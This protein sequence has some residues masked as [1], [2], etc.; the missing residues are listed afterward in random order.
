MASLMCCNVQTKRE[1]RWTNLASVPHINATR[2]GFLL[3]SPEK[4]SHAKTINEDNEQQQRLSHLK[5]FCQRRQKNHNNK[6][7][8]FGDSFIYNDKKKFV[9][10][11]IPK[12]A[13]TTWKKVVLYTLGI[14]DT[15]PVNTSLNTLYSYRMPYMKDFK[16]DTQRIK[17]MQ[18]NY[19]SFMLSRHPFDRL[20]SVY[21]NKFQNPV[22]KRAS[23]LHYFGPIILKV[24]GKNLNTHSK[25]IRHGIEYYDITFEEFLTFLTMGGYDADDHWTPQTSLCQICKYEFDF[26]GRF[27]HLSLDSNKIFKLIQTDINFSISH[28]YKQKTTDV[29]KDVYS[30]IPRTLLLKVYQVYKYDFDAFGYHPN[31]YFHFL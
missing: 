17:Y 7:L 18:D 8:K 24:T 19:F 14:V 31:E 23:F 1:D 12:V 20:F 25:K 6:T 2:S 29:L 30:K 16:N 26:I 28:D 15:H 22:V 5:D 11:R 27:E 13:C 9:Y 10:C 4:V 3:K 21:R